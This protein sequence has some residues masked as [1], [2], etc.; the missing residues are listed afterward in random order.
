MISGSILKYIIEF[1]IGEVRSNIK[2]NKLYQIKQDIIAYTNDIEEMKKYPI[3]IK[4]S[5]FFDTNVYG[6]LESEPKLPLHIWEG[7]PILFGSPKMEEI[8]DGKT[9]L[10]HADLIASTYYLISRYE[11]MTK[12]D[13]RDE[14]GRFPGMAS[15]PYRAGFI[16]RPIVDEYGAKLRQIIK[17]RNLLESLNISIEARPETFSMVTLSHDVDQPFKYR[18]WRSFFRAIIKEKLNPIK[19]FRYSFGSIY[20]DPYYTFP[21]ILEWNH[22][23]LDKLKSNQFRSIFFFKTPSNDEH[24]KPNY[25]MSSKAMRHLAKS[26]KRYKAKVGLH[27]NYEAGLNPKLIA[28]EKH[29]L[30]KQISWYNI[31]A[32]RHHFLSFREP[33]DYQYLLSAGIKHDFSMGYADIIGFR[34]GTCRP[35]RF[36]NPN[37]RTLTDL[38]MHPLYVMDYTLSAK[39]YM[40]LTHDKAHS[41]LMDIIDKVAKYNGD[42]SL[43]WHNET[44]SNV[45]E[46]KWLSILYR[47]ALRHIA[48]IANNENNI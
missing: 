8:N 12:R 21:K 22:L 2:D 37:T 4:P 44:F 10:I 23:L 11:E 33:E 19:A 17:E 34:L 30:Q 43:L 27:I 18:G 31:V 42:L 1:L 7:I 35:V 40:N 28:K 24:D 32:S 41:A 26:L 45:H 48:K 9:I 36:I 14:H 5:G 29:L 15:L 39:R 16:D 6:T 38:I 46:D 13:I 25:N 20:N 47:D 3:V